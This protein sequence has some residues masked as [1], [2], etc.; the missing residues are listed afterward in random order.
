MGENHGMAFRLI[1]AD[2]KVVTGEGEGGTVFR[3]LPDGTGIERWAIGFWNPF[4]TCETPNHHIF[5]VDN[6][7]DAMSS[8]PTARRG[9]GRRLRLSLSLWA[10]R[11]ASAPS[12]ERRVAGHTAADLRNRRG[13]DCDRFTSR[14]TLGHEL[15]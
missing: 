8:L 13:S 2:D 7:P 10:L 4:G 5:A 9:T 3:C 1:G 11:P 14:Q 12:L 6:D 15:G